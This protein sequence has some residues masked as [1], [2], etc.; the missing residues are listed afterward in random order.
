MLRRALCLLVAFVAL[1]SFA[2]AS[3]TL[4]LPLR[5][6]GVDDQTI[7]VTRD[8][9]AG[10]LGDLGVEVVTPD[11]LLAPLPMGSAA[12]DA[13]DCAAALG[14]QHGAGEVVYGSMSRLGAKF[15]VRLNVVRVD[16]TAPYYRDQ[17][18]STSE[19]D[20]DTVMRRFAEG[21]ASGRPN[22]DRATVESV[23][24]AETIEPTRRATRAGFG[25]RAGFLFPVGNSFGDDHP[26]TSILAA[27]KTEL[28]DYM[29]ETTPLIGFNWGDGNLDWTMLDVSAVR[30][31]G[32]SDMTG[33]AGFGVGVHTVTVA[34]NQV[35]TQTY[36][37]TPPYTYS[38]TSR[39]QQTRT[40]PTLD[41]IV[42]GM[43]LRTYDMSLILELRLHI[44]FATFDVLDDERANGL[45]L[46][47][48]TSR[49]GR[50]D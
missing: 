11:P 41:L 12:C 43:G 26:L 31:F 45:R 10:S 34:R 49:S 29:I 28:G 22:S 39:N 30:L 50:R 24:Q 2:A 47:F 33:F 6:I 21:I 4:V 14:R 13:P 37:G 25:V 17:L 7:V 44:V 1:P 3:P 38:Y 27:F 42:G 20:L 18:T 8:L 19:E 9:L 35:Y 46:T 5:S 36:P 23:I 16:D 48:G 40:V 32:K 15:I